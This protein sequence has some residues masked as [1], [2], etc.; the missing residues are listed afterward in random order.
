MLYLNKLNEVT[1]GLVEKYIVKQ[2]AV[3]SAD[4][5]RALGTGLQAPVDWGYGQAK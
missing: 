1:D 4:E 5:D 2:M 3:L